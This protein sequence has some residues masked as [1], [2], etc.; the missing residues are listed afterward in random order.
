V[1]ILAQN[2]GSVGESRSSPRHA[3]P[4]SPLPPRSVRT[5]RRPAAGTARRDG[6][7]LG[8][9][10][11]GTMTPRQVGLEKHLTRESISKRGHSRRKGRHLRQVQRHRIGEHCGAPWP[12]TNGRLNV[13]HLLFERPAPE[14]LR[15]TGPRGIRYRQKNR[16]ASVFRGEPKLNQDLRVYERLPLYP[17]T[18]KESPQPT[19]MLFG[20]VLQYRAVRRPI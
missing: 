20:K 6:E 11:E 4:V 16:T 15:L 5:P 12:P 1:T 13:N 7:L 2:V 14:G 17:I 3:A 19:F 8:K 9:M 18:A 10:S